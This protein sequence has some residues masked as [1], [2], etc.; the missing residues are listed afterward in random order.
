LIVLII[1]MALVLFIGLLI[2]I[3]NFL[4]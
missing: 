4:L 2:Y 3:A 1:V